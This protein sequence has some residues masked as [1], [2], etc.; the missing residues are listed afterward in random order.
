LEKADNT[1]IWKTIRH[2]N[3][4]QRAIPLLNS[5]T[6]LHDKCDELRNAL[7]PPRVTD[8]TPSLPENIS[9]K[10]DL[11]DEIGLIIRREISRT[12]RHLNLD[13]APGNDGL[14]YQVIARFD[15]ASP[16]S[17]PLLLNAMLKYS[18]YPVS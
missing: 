3:T 11:S 12:I 2:Y 5:K 9:Y 7:F 4:F 8:P 10:E 17:L 18:V 6:Q 16:T 15:E 1:T 13:S 14:G